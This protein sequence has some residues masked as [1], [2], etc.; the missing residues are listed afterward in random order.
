MSLSS[1]WEV[2]ARQLSW[3]RQLRNG[4]GGRDDN[5]GTNNDDNNNA[6]MTTTTI[7]TMAAGSVRSTW[8]RMQQLHSAKGRQRKTT[9]VNAN[10]NVSVS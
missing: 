9:A 7:T 2:A 1:W 6:E 5:N 10:V 4:R 3:R 8:E